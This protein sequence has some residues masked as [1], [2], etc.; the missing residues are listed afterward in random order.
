LDCFIVA[1]KYKLIADSLGLSEWNEVVWIGRYFTLDNDYGEYWFDNWEQRDA[2]EVKALQLGIN[3][4]DLLVL[5]PDRFK[6][7][8][9][10]PCHSDEERISFWKDVLISLSL[11]YNTMVSEAR[12]FNEERKQNDGENYITDLE[13]RINS[14]RGN[15][16]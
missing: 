6:N 7:N 15:L 12:N 11:S 5:D 9:D 1:P 2:I 13:E 4:H 14:I 10:G 16:H 3:H 8:Y